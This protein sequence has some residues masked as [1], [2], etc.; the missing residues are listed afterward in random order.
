MLELPGVIQGKN[1]TKQPRGTHSRHWHGG[2]Q[3]SR[4]TWTAFQCPTLSCTNNAVEDRVQ[5]N[6]VPGASSA[7]SP[8]CIGRAWGGFLESPVFVPIG[9][10]SV[11]RIA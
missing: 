9:D 10:D 8:A 11:Y 6:S 3:A 2:I 1:R 5:R 4:F 7:A